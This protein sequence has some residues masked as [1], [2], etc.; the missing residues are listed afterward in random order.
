MALSLTRKARAIGLTDR[1]QTMRSATAICCDAGS[2][3]WQQ[4]N[5]RRMMSSR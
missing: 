2:S 1:P 4:M 5:S 3:G